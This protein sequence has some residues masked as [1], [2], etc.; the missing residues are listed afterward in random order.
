MPI[1][2]APGKEHKR[3]CDAEADR[4]R[5]KKVRLRRLFTCIRC[6]AFSMCFS[7]SCVT[8]LSS[9]CLPFWTCLGTPTADPVG[10]TLCDR[11][12]CIGLP[13]RAPSDH[14]RGAGLCRCRRRAGRLCGRSSQTC[15]VARVEGSYEAAWEKAKKGFSVDSYHTSPCL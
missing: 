11:S 5:L 3:A 13:R 6:E 10:T 9:L 1:Q 2:R 15:G 8:N 7:L 4:G 14:G 12:S